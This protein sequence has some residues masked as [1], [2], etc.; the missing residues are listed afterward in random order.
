MKQLSDN[1]QAYTSVLHYINNHPHL[2]IYVVDRMVDMD[3][4]D[5]TFDGFYMPDTGRLYMT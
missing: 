1:R 2:E 3:K 5:F 4:F